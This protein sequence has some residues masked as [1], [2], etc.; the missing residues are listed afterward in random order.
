MP[1][2][3]ISPQ[4]RDFVA[5]RAFDCCEYCWSQ[6][7][8]STEPFSVE[9]I[10]ALS[11]GGA[12]THENMAFACGGCNDHKYAKTEAIDPLESVF[13]PLFHPRKQR[14]LDHF[15]WNSDY[16]LILGI[17]PIGRATVD[18]L[19]MNRPSLINLRKALYA[20]GEHPPAIFD[21]QRVIK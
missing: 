3:R 20:Y 18:A 16:T 2:V 12:N 21:Y 19:K 14:W 13:V 6:A 5:E 7:D 10:I 4:L 15:Q 11:R 8:F 9:H 1:K 17:T